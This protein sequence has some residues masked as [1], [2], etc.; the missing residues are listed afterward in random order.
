VAE[1]D[2]GVAPASSC[3]AAF[4]ADQES[5]L[6]KHYPRTVPT[7][8]LALGGGQVRECEPLLA[9]PGLCLRF[10]SGGQSREFIGRQRLGE[11]LA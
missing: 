9:S 7:E 11:Q 1:P 10:E 3:C 4:R 6:Q 2:E 8:W 5:W